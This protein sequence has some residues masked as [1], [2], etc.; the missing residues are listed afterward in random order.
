MEEPMISEEL[1]TAEMIFFDL[2]NDEKLFNR[3]KFMKALKTERSRK[4]AIL[5][6]M[7]GKLLFTS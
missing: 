6:T 2:L 5:R 1:D 7:R 4:A 3:D